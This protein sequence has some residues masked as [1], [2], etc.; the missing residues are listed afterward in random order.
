MRQPRTSLTFDRQM[1]QR[2]CEG[3]RRWGLRISAKRAARYE[4]RRSGQTIREYRC[5]FCLCYHIGHPIR[6]DRRGYT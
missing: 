4:S 6:R 2:G 3:K 1:Y 5:H